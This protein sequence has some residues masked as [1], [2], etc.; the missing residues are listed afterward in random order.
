M[1][2]KRQRMVSTDLAIQKRIF[3]EKKYGLLISKRGNSVFMLRDDCK[4]INKY[5]EGFWEIETDRNTEIIERKI[6]LKYQ[7]IE[8]ILDEIKELRN[9]KKGLVI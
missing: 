9:Q 6:L 7:A 4:S 5:Y 2:T 8:L 3:N 1:E